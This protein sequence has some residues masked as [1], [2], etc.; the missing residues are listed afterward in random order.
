[1]ESRLAAQAASSTVRTWLKQP[2]SL[3]EIRRVGSS[4]AVPVDGRTPTKGID[5]AF[6]A[7]ARDGREGVTEDFLVALDSAAQALAR[8]SG[9]RLLV[10]VIASPSLSREAED[11]LN[12]I[13]EFCQANAIR[14]IVLDSSQTRA[15][16]APTTSLG[17]LSTRTGGSVVRDPKSLDRAILMAAAAAIEPL[18]A[19]I[20]P[21][22]ESRQF[23][24]DIP[25]RL[26]F[27]RVNASGFQSYGTERSVSAGPG[28]LTERTGGSITE[29]ST[30]PSR[31]LFVVE[32]PFSALHFD[33]DDNSG[34]YQARAKVT[35]I[36]RNREG[37]IV[38]QASKTM[39]L[40][41]PLRKLRARR[42]GNLYYL[43]AVQLPAGQYTLEATVEDLIA[44]KSGGVR[45][46]LRTSRAIP[47]FDVSDA[48]VVR[49]YNGGGDRLEADQIFAYDGNAIAPL[50][51]PIYDGTKPIDLNLYFIIYPDL[52]GPQPE[53]SLE[54][55]QSDRVI[56]RTAL[57]FTDRIRDTGTEGKSGM[58]AERKHQFPYMATLKG[59]KLGA[60]EYEARVIVRQDR[61][62]LAR[63]TRFQVIGGADTTVSSGAIAEKLAPEENLADVVLPEVDPV[64][65]KIAAALPEEE[66]RKQWDEAAAEARAYS[67]RLPNFRCNRETRR[68]TA[69]VKKADQFTE[70]DSVKEE[71]TYEN[72]NET[73]RTLEINGQKSDTGRGKLHGVQ[74]SGEFGTILRYIFR[75][76]ISAK[77]RWAGRAMIGGT[78]CMVYE[79]DVP[80]E[81]SNFVLTADLKQAVAP[82]RG[83]VM[84]DEETGL[85]RR[86]V[87]QGGMLP[88]GFD[89]QSPVL[90]LEYGMVRVGDRDH[91]LPL[92]SVL[93]LR[94]GRRVVRNE[95]LFRE[96]RKFEAESQIKFE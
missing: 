23:A 59:V 75:P 19:A 89:L 25:V 15:K 30:G 79:F 48:L 2:G 24:S 39:N 28:G 42:E 5:E 50:L 77:A 60:G 54:L 52:F 53:L 20:A 69:S 21:A 43:R 74:S 62:V 44:G 16:D 84:V 78:L 73:Y 1:V 34:Q 66:V 40:Q 68:L 93:Q 8:R 7:A 14:V 3:A 92:R 70:A 31:G 64:E 32:S 63:S 45:E 17:G 76:D 36:A 35:Q 81:K 49:P 72:G 65:M 38:W 87:M 4:D 57:P 18:S 55:L 82:Y 41:G 11:T 37:K 83:R 95:T 94:Q 29:A 71:L 85:V 67:S 46:P 13:A 96:Y 80:V 90:S 27:A 91:L 22:S 33:V 58:I 61:N 26:R 56:A 47:G 51:H 9:L 86:I 12:G 10:A 6:L 88:K